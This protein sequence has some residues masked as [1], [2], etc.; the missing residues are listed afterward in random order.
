MEIYVVS[1]HVQARGNW[2]QLRAAVAACANPW[3]K[4]ADDTELDEFFLWEVCFG[5]RWMSAE[6]GWISGELEGLLRRMD[7]LVTEI[8][9][10]GP[11]LF[12]SEGLRSSPLWARLRGLALEGLK[13]MPEKPWE[14]RQAAY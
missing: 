11:P 13:L 5:A 10:A 7:T 4:Q 12:E 9:S 3:D 8:S 6:A 1:E 2:L 14:G